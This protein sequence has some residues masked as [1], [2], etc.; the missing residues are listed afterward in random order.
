[1][2]MPTMRKEASPKPTAIQCSSCLRFIDLRSMRKRR[3]QSSEVLLV[4]CCRSLRARACVIMRLSWT[5]P[6]K[7]LLRLASRQGLGSTR[8]GQ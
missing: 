8:S 6:P 1:M 5:Q 2:P 4:M 7:A 3:A